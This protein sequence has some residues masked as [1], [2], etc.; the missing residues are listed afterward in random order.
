MC[1]I[2]KNRST[3]HHLLPPPAPSP[4][5]LPT[6]RPPRGIELGARWVDLSPVAKSLVR[7]IP[8]ALVSHEEAAV[9]TRVVN[10][11]FLAGS[12]HLVA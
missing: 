10:M 3:E 4:S 6:P 5:P 7:L 12:Q 8:V 11:F 1:W 9:F 2:L